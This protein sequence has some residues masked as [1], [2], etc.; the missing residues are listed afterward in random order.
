MSATKD[1]LIN[2]KLGHIN[3]GE[4]T[5]ILE[6]PIS[7]DLSKADHGGYLMV[8]GDLGILT[9]GNSL[10]EMI[11]DI[12][13]QFTVLW[14]EYVRS[15]DELTTSGQM[16]KE[17]LV[18]RFAMHGIVFGGNGKQQVKGCKPLIVMEELDEMRYYGA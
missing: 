8:N 3:I 10:E 17:A 6:E 12:N 11:K 18:D 1:I 15:D 14:G 13:E 9:I 5:I 4:N 7:L 2:F 16:L